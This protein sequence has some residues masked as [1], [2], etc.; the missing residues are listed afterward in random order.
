MTRY[1][2]A[3]CLVLLAACGGESGQSVLSAPSPASSPSSSPAAVHASPSPVPTTSPIPPK[4]AGPHFDSPEAAMR[5]LAAAWN[6]R[7]LVS[8][9]HVTDPAARERLDEMHSEAIN[10]QLDR[11]T[12]NKDRGDYECFFD[13]DYPA[14]YPAASRNPKGGQAEFTV[15]PADRPGWYMTYFVACG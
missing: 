4:Q 11:C 7:D 14:S 3:L 5:Y 8:L 13:H 1:A 10:L 6:R 9:K 12:L 15:G 2:A